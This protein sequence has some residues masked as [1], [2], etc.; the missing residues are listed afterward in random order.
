MEERKRRIYFNKLK[1]LQVLNQ[2]LLVKNQLNNNNMQIKQLTMDK[3]MRNQVNK[4]LVNINSLMEMCIILYINLVTLD[5]G[6][7]IY[8][9]VKVY[10]FL[11]MEKDMKDI[12]KV[13]RNMVLVY[14]IMQMEIHIM[15]NG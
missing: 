14:I 13:V 3:W 12:Y 9:M 11:I 1:S 10:I 7:T 6:L 15:E 5:N 4:E 8:L 2:N